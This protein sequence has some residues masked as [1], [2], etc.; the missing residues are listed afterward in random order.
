MI[1]N[2]KVLLNSQVRPS[3]NLIDRW[4]TR[5]QVANCGITGLP[6]KARTTPF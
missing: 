2:V 5:S 4:L 1:S 3:C 6:Q